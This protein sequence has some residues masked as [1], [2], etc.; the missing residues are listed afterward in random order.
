MATRKKTSVKPQQHQHVALVID[1]SGSMQHLRQ[2]LVTTV[3]AE[4]EKIRESAR[5]YKIK[6]TITLVKFASSARVFRTE[7]VET[8]T[9]TEH[10]YIPNGQ[11][12]LFDGLDLAIETVRQ[13]A[14][15]ETS[16]L[17]RL[18]TDGEE[19]YSGMFKSFSCDRKD[20]PR[21]VKEKILF[22]EQQGNWTFAFQ[23]TQ[24]ERFCREYGFTSDNVHEWQ[25]LEQAQVV[26]VA[27]VDH[28]YQTRS[29]GAKASNV[30][31]S[32]VTDLTKVDDVIDQLVDVTSD[33]KLHNVAKD[34]QMQEIAEL[35]DKKNEYVA[36]D[37]KW[38]YQ[39]YKQE[40]IQPA[41]QIVLFDKRDKK[42]YGG[43]QA[44][45]II[46]LKSDGVGKVEPGNHA[47]YDVFVQS[48]ST[49]RKLPRGTKV[50]QKK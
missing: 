39:L 2:K 21:Q 27:A 16:F 36:K 29:T 44:R 4:I 45:K 23:V 50:L 10:D 37:G 34:C 9:F 8:F 38:F 14:N 7:D 30:Y 12:A 48:T 43:P 33:Y 15:L 49:N 24:K 35:K 47:D 17:V 6:T 13:Y 41:K 22:L 19:N 42:M 3:Q 40:K 25:T 28:Y 5:K 20:I 31:Y 26:N 18:F 46:G 1:E 32:A 11:T